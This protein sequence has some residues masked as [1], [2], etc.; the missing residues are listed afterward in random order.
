MCQNCVL[1]GLVKNC[2][3]S[4]DKKWNG[5]VLPFGKRRFGAVFYSW[6]FHLQE[7]SPCKVIKNQ[8][9]AKI[10]RT[11]HLDKTVNT[12]CFCRKTFKSTKSGIRGPPS[13]RFRSQVEASFKKAHR[14]MYT[15][16]SRFVSDR[17]T[18]V[19][20]LTTREWHSPGNLLMIHKRDTLR[21]SVFFLRQT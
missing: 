9:C 8:I 2:R 5:M 11:C 15:H 21:N 19:I 16:I 17:K 1:Q 4:A 13:P 20:F 12:S 7:R 18:T 6:Q 14:Q 3:P 10:L